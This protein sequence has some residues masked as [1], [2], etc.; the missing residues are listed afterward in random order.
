M[1]LLTSNYQLLTCVCVAMSVTASRVGV[2]S[3]EEKY[4]RIG[5]KHNKI[6]VLDKF[7]DNSLDFLKHELLKNSRVCYVLFLVKS[8]P[9]SLKI[10]FFRRG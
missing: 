2:A 6:I 10:L 7:S 8:P 5:T 9:P 1:C 4:S 3:N